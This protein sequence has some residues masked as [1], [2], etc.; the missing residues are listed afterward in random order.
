M[1]NKATGVLCDILDFS[2]RILEE[3]EL[4]KEGLAV[5]RSNK[6]EEMMMKRMFRLILI[7]FSIMLLT[8]VAVAEEKEKK[9]YS[10]EPWEKAALY[11]GAFVVD[12]NSDLELGF[13]VGPRSCMK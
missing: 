5:K 3:A 9:D 10:N 6:M 8:Q 11:L 1:K 12:M 7:L 4:F 13:D 2:K